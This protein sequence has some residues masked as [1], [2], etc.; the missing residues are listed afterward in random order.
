MFTTGVYI[1]SPIFIQNLTISI[2]AYAR[3]L[4]RENKTS[5]SLANKLL[6][7]EK[8]ELELNK[9]SELELMTQLKNAADNSIFYKS[10]ALDNISLKGFPLIDKNDIR[11]RS[12]E[13]LSAIKPKVI[14]NGSTSGTTGTPLSIPQSMESV[15]REQAFI[16]RALRWAGF[17]EGD[18]RAWIRGDMIVPIEQKNAPFWRYSYFED[19]ILLSSYHMSQEAMPFYLEAMVKYGV[20]IIQA[21]PSSIVTL[22]KYLES[23]NLFYNGKLK[24]I[25]TSSESLSKED[26]ILIEER[27]KC[28]VFDWYGLFERVAAIASCE[29][30]RYHILTDYS[31]VELQPNEGKDGI[32]RAEII[33]T[34]FNNHLYP[35]IRYKT[36]DHVLL[37]KEQKCPCGR[38]YPLVDSIE[39]RI[40]DYLMA[41]NGQK[42]H[43][44]NH[45]P[46]GV[47]GLLATQFIQD[48]INEV[49]VLVVVDSKVYTI[50]QE[51]AL[52]NNVKER[53]G[54]EVSVKI[55]QVDSISRTNNGKVRQAICRVEVI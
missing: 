42:I 3:K 52:I 25:M 12:N 14:V 41:A 44:L 15:I 51:R 16:T 5:K 35:L 32:E 53:L 29:H 1:K 11:T 9:Y 36:G 34:N 18:K 10:L 13:F 48:C 17:E 22:A 31:Y 2:R 7:L 47:C 24:S 33:G 49:T 21:Y 20:N 39:G 54:G 55:Q 8:N 38:V 27:F 6:N 43:I 4:I 30:G 50:L 40:G 26:K 46:K 23:N 19:M 28:T 37:S 45:I